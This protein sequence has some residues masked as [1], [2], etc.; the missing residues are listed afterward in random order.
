MSNATPHYDPS[1]YSNMSVF[2]QGSRK[3]R[4]DKEVQWHPLKAGWNHLRIMGPYFKVAQHW[5]ET[6][7]QKRFSLLCPEFDPFTGD[8]TNVG[9]CPIEEEFGSVKEHPDEKMKKLSPRLTAFTQVIVRD[10]QAQ[11]DQFP[12]KPVR[13]PI[14]TLGN[15]RK[16]AQLNLNASNEPTDVN[17]PTYGCDVMIN[18]D[19]QAQGAERYSVT[20]AQGGKIPLTE[21]EMAYFQ[22]PRFIIWEN[23]IQYPTKAEIKEALSRNGYYAVAG[24]TANAENVTNL[25]VSPTSQAST[26]APPVGPAAPQAPAPAYAA[27]V[28][29]PAQAPAQVAPQAPA[30]VAPVAPVAPQAPAQVAPV[31]PQAPAQVAPVAPQTPTNVAAPAA[32]SEAQFSLVGRNEQVGKSEFEAAILNYSNTL[33]AKGVARGFNE[34]GQL[35]TWEKDELNGISVLNCFGSYKGDPDCIRCPLRKQ[36]LIY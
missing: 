4:W 34:Q 3:E 26:V 33:Q 15:I 28:A 20:L 5:F 31:A 7:T 9:C 11:G 24:G 13:L 2:N 8:Y 19:P 16:Q 25:S 23:I 29:P 27:P 22:D 30:Q 1:K 35:K 6:P 32:T 36:C 14:T 10:F 18:Y 17:D 21:A 12:V